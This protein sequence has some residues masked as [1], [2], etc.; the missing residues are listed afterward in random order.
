MS[1]RASSGVCA[2]RRTAHRSVLFAPGNHPRR[3][4]KVWDC[5]ADTVV[6]DLEDAVPTADKGAARAEV[7]DVLS[8][9]SGTAGAAVR[10][11]GI[12][13]GL[14]EQDVAAVVGAGIEG[15]VLPKVQSL[16]DLVEADRAV[17][18]A[19]RAAGTADGSTWLLAIIESA[20][21]VVNVER[22]CAEAPARLA[23]VALGWVDLALDIGAELSRDTSPFLYARSRLVAASRAAGLAAPI[24][25]PWL[26]VDDADGLEQD[27]EHSRR[28]GFGG[29]IVIHPNQVDVVIGAYGLAEQDL[30][31]H[32][33]I[34]HGF[35]A[36]LEEGSASIQV[37]GQFV[38]YPVYERSRAELRRQGAGE[39]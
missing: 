39:T 9:R 11:N 24:D 26:W 23:A 28:I 25:G 19:E 30:E 6:L 1:S 18:D 32:R 15:I 22:I 20:T 27:S 13:S 5:G 3:A 14:F 12:S 37:N 7:V 34:V 31:R 36:A 29:R 35:E 8:G 4:R 16:D 38:D 10:V 2:W 33:E 21:A 17:L